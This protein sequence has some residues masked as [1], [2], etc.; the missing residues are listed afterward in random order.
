MRIDSLEG[1]SGITEVEYVDLF[2]EI[3][4][5]LIFLL[6]WQIILLNFSN[7]PPNLI[8]FFLLLLFESQLLQC[9]HD[10]KDARKPA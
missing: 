4:T 9:K 2:L 3:L 8:I 6:C 10:R 1:N 7:F 5:N